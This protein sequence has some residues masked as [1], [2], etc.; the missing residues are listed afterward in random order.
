MS[1][2]LTNSQVDTLKQKYVR[3]DRCLILTKGVYLQNLQ[4]CVQCYNH[5][6]QHDLED[7]MVH[8][9]DDSD[10]ENDPDS[11]ILAGTDST[12]SARGVARP[13]HQL[14]LPYH[15]QIRPKLKG[16]K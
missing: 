15:H 6:K 14:T 13:W 3:S 10:K 4:L 7:G 2:T 1:S 12:I 11:I 9:D 5:R 16:S 8:V